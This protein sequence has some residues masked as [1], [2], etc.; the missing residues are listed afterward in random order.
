MPDPVTIAI[1]AAAIGTVGKIYGSKSSQKASRENA[2]RQMEQ[3]RKAAEAEKEQN[4]Y[5][6]YVS[7]LNERI[8]LDNIIKLNKAEG[9]NLQENY[10]KLNN[11]L[12]TQQVAT[13]ASGFDLSSG[14]LSEV[15]KQSMVENS[16]DAAAIRDSF[17]NGRYEFGM[18]AY[19]FKMQAKNFTDAAARYWTGDYSLPKRGSNLGLYLDAFGTGLGMAARGNYSSSSA[20]ASGSSGV[21]VPK[22]NNS[23]DTTYLA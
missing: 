7:K 13:S 3:A 4:L 8:Q 5:N 6:A 14:T 10:N 15:E 21:T 12:K 20:S 19:Q 16:L 9:L 18:K 2:R 23:S 17:S 22:Y 11:L 1:A